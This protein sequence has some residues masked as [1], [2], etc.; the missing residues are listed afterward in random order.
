MVLLTSRLN[1]PKSYMYTAFARAKLQRLPGVTV[2]ARKLVK[3][4]TAKPLTP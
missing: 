1:E 3:V 2:E 4:L